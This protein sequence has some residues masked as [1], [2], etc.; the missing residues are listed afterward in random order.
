[1]RS[2]AGKDGRALAGRHRNKMP[3]TDQLLS[4]P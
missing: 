4:F 3:L 2:D 1:V